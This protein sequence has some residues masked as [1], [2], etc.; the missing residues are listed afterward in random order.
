[1]LCS[2]ND[3]V[4]VLPCATWAYLNGGPF[5]TCAAFPGRRLLSGRPQ[6]TDLVVGWSASLVGLVQLGGAAGG[7]R[8]AEHDEGADDDPSQSR[9]S[10]SP[11]PAPG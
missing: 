3:A 5:L 10:V 11:I 1:L 6:T 7:S 8:Q 4:N 9:L 2:V